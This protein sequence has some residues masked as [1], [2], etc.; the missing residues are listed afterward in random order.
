MLHIASVLDF[1]HHVC[2]SCFINIVR[3]RC[4]LF[5]GVHVRSRLLNVFKIVFW[6]ILRVR[7]PKSAYF[8]MTLYELQP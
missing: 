1:L 4:I 2:K 7:K 3:L 6:S 8:A 5:S